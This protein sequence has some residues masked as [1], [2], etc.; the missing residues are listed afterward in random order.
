MCYLMSGDGAYQDYKVQVQGQLWISERDWVDVFSYH[1]E[2]PP[3]IVRME[4]DEN[5]IAQ[6]AALVEEF[7][8]EL[9]ELFIK[10]QEH[11]W[12]KTQEQILSDALARKMEGM[13]A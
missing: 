4:R 9:E 11:R 5:F 6:L 1:P 3:A 10:A 7:S 2:L 13:M 8:R 12:V